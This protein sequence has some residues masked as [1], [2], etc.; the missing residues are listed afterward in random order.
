[1]RT[2]ALMR[3]NRC[4]RVSLF[5]AAVGAYGIQPADAFLA[6]PHFWA[7]NTGLTDFLDESERL[8][9][10]ARGL[11][12]LSNGQVDI[13]VNVPESVAEYHPLIPENLKATRYA[14]YFH[15]DS[16]RDAKRIAY[17]AAWLER[18]AKAALADAVRDND[19]TKILNTLGIV[20]HAVQDIYTHSNFSATA[21]NDADVA[22]RRASTFVSW[23]GRA[24]PT[25]DEIPEDIWGSP[26]LGLQSG[27]YPGVPP[28]DDHGEKR[29]ERAHS[30]QKPDGFVWPY[31]SEHQHN[32]CR[33][34]L[35]VDC[36]LH[37]DNVGRPRHLTALLMAA[38]ATADW[39]RK[40]QKWVND[41]NLWNRVKG[42]GERE[43]RGAQDLVLGSLANNR[44]KAI[45][46]GVWTWAVE[47]SMAS[48]AAGVII[49]SDLGFSYSERW[50]NN[51]SSA[52]FRMKD[53]ADPWAC[54]QATIRRDGRTTAGSNCW[55]ADRFGLADRRAAFVGTYQVLHGNINATLTLSSAPGAGKVTGSLR[56][57]NDGPWKVT[58]EV[59]NHRLNFNIEK[60]QETTRAGVVYLIVRRDHPTELAGFLRNSVGVPKG[61]SATRTAEPG[62]AMQE[63]G[64]KK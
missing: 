45:G 36:G 23:L 17:D 2:A 44:G 39:T 62:R 61:F 57:G 26:A 10:L 30:F 41:E 29:A 31:H 11:V 63:S 6:A 52:L 56:F 34:D 16:L 5:V 12:N 37:K 55:E 21:R 59:F 22:T 18:G 64:G 50:A 58:G 43:W 49:A 20:L 60:K 48:S 32:R 13:I 35:P 42:W 7:T 25:W 38:R 40:F 4:F 15:F 8:S 47:R 27:R 28:S 19:P 53:A 9:P 1:M 51:W 46:A 3:C 54:D 33:T 14:R 24:F